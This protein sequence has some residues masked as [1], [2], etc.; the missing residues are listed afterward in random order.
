MCLIL[1]LAG[2][3][4]FVSLGAAAPV[5]AQEA[6]AGQVKAAFL[7]NFTKFVEWPPSA[8]TANP[9]T[10]T[11]GILEREPLAPALEALQGKEVQ[12]RK[13]VVKRCRH[14]EELKKCQIFF[15][16]AAEKPGLAEI[17]AAL[18]GLPVLTVTDE[19]DDFAKLGGMINLTRQEDKIRF[20]IDVNNAERSGLKISSQLLKLAFRSGN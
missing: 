12:G 17:M 2:W 6:S 7:F 20:H 8:F 18:K 19:V 4:L 11:L 13:L 16:S 1:L 15:A 5:S 10:I 3:W 14:H 9:A